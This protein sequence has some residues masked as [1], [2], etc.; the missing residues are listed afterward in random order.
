MIFKLQVGNWRF[1][2]TVAPVTTVIGVNS[3]LPD[4]RHILMW[5]FDDTSLEEVIKSLQRVQAIYDLPPIHILQTKTTN[6]EFGKI[7]DYMPFGKVQDLTITG[8]F[9]AYCFKALPWRKVIEVI[10]FTKGVDANFF[11]Y[12]VYRERFTLRVT[13]KGNRE[14]HWIHTMPSKVAPDVDVKDLKSWV[15]YQTLQD[16][17]KSRKILVGIDR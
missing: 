17:F 9:I 10:A 15:K 6:I 12:G 13:P 7:I 4:G 11:K 1:T 16:G 8:N 2:F 14:P 3:Q 5:D